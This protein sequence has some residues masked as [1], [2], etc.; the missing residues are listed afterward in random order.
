MKTNQPFE[1]NKTYHFYNRGNNGENIFKDAENYLYFL[2]LY[3]KHV[4]PLTNTF[5][6]C[7]MP[8]HFH[9][10]IE[11]TTQF[12]NKDKNPVSQAFSNCFNAYSKA[13]NKRYNRH[14]S[15]FET[16][17]K[18]IVV[19]TADY[20]TALIYYIHHNPV[21]HGFTESPADWPYSSYHAFLSDKPT[22]LRRESVLDWFGGKDFFEKIHLN[23]WDPA[24]KW[25]SEQKKY[26][27][28]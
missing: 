7:L 20:F 21:K 22:Q 19:E 5:A 6:Y 24:L 18:R 9:F 23:Q 15:L 14:G 4:L 16:H 1:T 10:L 26:I 25:N 8:N 17:P 2:N 3:K 12:E 13:I 28:R 11:I 27:V